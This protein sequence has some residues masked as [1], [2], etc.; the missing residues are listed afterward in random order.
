VRLLFVKEALAWPRCS[1]HD[2]HCSQM[3]RALAGRG[4]AVSLATLKAPADE[5]VR[6]LGLERLETF[7]TP[8][9]AD[10]SGPDLPLSGRQ[11]RFRSYWGIEPARIRAVARIAAACR[12][13]AVVVVGLNVLPYLGAVTGALRVWYAADEWAWHHLS[14]VSLLRPSTWGNLKQALVKGLYER[15]YAPLLDRVWV[16]SDPDRRAMRWF[17]G[18]RRLDVV[19]NGVDGEYFAPRDVPQL[20]RSCVF[21]GRLDFGPNQQALEWFC[22]R[23]WPAVR[24]AAPDAQF[25]VYGFNPTPEARALAG[26]DGVELVPDLPDLRPEIARHQAVVLPFVSGGGIKN[27]LLEAAGMGKPIVC[28][29]R[30]CGGLH[31]AEP[32]PVLA[33]SGPA[34]WADTLLRLWSDPDLRRRQ[35]E[36]A[37]RW[38]LRW[39]TWEAAARTAEAGLEE[40]LRGGRT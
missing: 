18:V 26:R 40:G 15:A 1:G 6:G 4:H 39:H 29:P 13:E 31:A 34:A 2:V 36:D 8:D 14:Q 20:E 3:M 21:W 37:R 12:A 23:A 33:A 19:P 24:R 32:A 11:E 30:A 38:V 35:G 7:G 27:K 5:S 22:R 17:A 9:A 16:V 28:T 25:D 10:L